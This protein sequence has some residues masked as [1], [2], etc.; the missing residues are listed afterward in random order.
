MAGPGFS[1]RRFARAH[2]RPPKDGMTREEV[3]YELHLQELLAEGRVHHV[4]PHEPLKLVL[5]EKCSYQPDFLVVS[6]D[7]VVELHDVKGRKVV[8]EKDER[9]KV[10]AERETYWVE[11]DSKLKIRLAAALAFPMFRFFIVWPLRSGAWGREIF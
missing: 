10:I 7:D 6:E 4:S 11:E 9:G 5:A 3:A 8:K 2:R 1:G